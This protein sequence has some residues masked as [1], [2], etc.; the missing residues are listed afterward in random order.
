MGI[1]HTIDDALLNYFHLKSSPFFQ[2]GSVHVIFKIASACGG[3]RGGKRM[4]SGR[5]RIFEKILNGKRSL[6]NIWTEKGL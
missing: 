3:G 4:N 6:K 2:V 1:L 5:K